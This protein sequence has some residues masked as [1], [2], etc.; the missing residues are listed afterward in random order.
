METK[1][2]SKYAFKFIV[3]KIKT[4]STQLNYPSIFHFATRGRC[5]SIF[6]SRLSFSVSEQD[7]VFIKICIGCFF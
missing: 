3:E 5:C 4:C 7:C 2:Q 1:S 6:G